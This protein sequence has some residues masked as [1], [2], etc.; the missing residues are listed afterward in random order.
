MHQHLIIALSYH[1]FGHIGQTAPIVHALKKCMPD[2]KITIQSS[3]PEEK[4]IERFGT[5][6]QIIKKQMDIGMIQ[7]DAL[8]VDV[9]KSFLAYR[10]FHK[11]WKMKIEQEA[12][13]LSDLNADLVLSNI[14][15][16][17]LAGAHMANIPSLAYCSLNWADIFEY[18]L[19]ASEK[20]QQILQE[21][22]NAYNTAKGFISPEPSMTMSRLN[23]KLTV[24][25]V[26]Q[27]GID[28][29]QEILSRIGK[30]NDTN[31]V[32][33]SVGGMDLD[34]ATESWP[35]LPNTVIL[36][37]DSWNIKD[38]T[39]M[40]NINYFG[41]KFIDLMHSC[42]VLIT[43]PGYGSFVEAACTGTPVLYIE[44]EN[45]PE[46]PALVTWLQ[47]NGRCLKL[48][49]NAFIKGD[50]FQSIRELTKM[51]CPAKSTPTGIDDAVKIIQGFL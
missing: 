35:I 18:Y 27:L 15:Y 31:I 26:A 34:I 33:I 39:D 49:L 11:D 42:D 4:L 24:G 38:R 6:I 29:R 2:L 30:T 10:L 37:P 28:H 45:W 8:N 7:A 20:S 12:R 44:R 19:G 48:E 1:G 13:T 47:K 50:F 17:A 43:K 25:P 46:M 36:V 3:A 40:F 51:Q 5:E 32:L 16:L 9:E 22:I 41:Y 14:S 23:N 21:I